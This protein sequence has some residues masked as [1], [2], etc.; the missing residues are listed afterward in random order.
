MKSIL[1]IADK[2]NWAVDIRVKQIFKQLTQ[3]K[4]TEVYHT[5]I[6][7]DVIRDLA[8]K[9]DAVWCCNHDTGPRHWP[10]FTELKH[11]RVFVTFRSWRYRVEAVPFINSGLVKAVSAVSRRLSAHIQEQ[12]KL[13]VVYIP[14]GVPDFFT[15]TR[16]PFIGFVGRPDEYKGYPM[17]KEA[18]RRCG[19]RLAVA[20]QS[21]NCSITGGKLRPQTDMPDFYASCDAIVVASLQEGGGTIAMEAMAMNIPVL[22]TQ[23]GVAADLDCIYIERSVEGIEAG[24]KK[25]FGRSKVFPEFSVPVVC[26][27]YAKLFDMVLS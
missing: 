15:P 11:P 20:P 21:E 6:N 12:T 3:Y 2:P 7:S 16:M 13:P 1:A 19:F 8:P 25:L 27:Q 23:V 9:H 26:E 4:V 5:R 18:V 24:L 14:E 22:T 10:V 17:I